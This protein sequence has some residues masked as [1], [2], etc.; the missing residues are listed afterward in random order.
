[1]SN[2]IQI[3]VSFPRYVLGLPF[4]KRMTGVFTTTI[5][6]GLLTEHSYKSYDRSHKK[7]PST[8]EFV[9]FHN[10]IADNSFLLVRTLKSFLATHQSYDTNSVSLVLLFS[11]FLPS[12][13]KEES[14]TVYCA[15][16]I[17]KLHC[18]FPC[19]LLSCPYHI[20]TY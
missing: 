8:Q 16:Y 12:F 10:N 13:L 14:G 20:T 18:S 2:S 17:G 9:V 1:M 3:F 6:E 4:G 5:E 11:S 7:N 15:G 19:Y